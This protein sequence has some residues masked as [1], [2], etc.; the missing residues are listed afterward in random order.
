M[1]ILP[2]LLDNAYW[3]V[4]K[5]L[6]SICSLVEPSKANDLESRSYLMVLLDEL[7]HN[8]KHLYSGGPP[9]IR[10]LLEEKTKCISNGIHAVPWASFYAGDH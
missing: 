4:L 10:K 2:I 7:R 6:M 8:W 9:S 3:Q 5:H 1:I